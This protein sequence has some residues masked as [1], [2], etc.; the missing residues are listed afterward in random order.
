MIGKLEMMCESSLC[1]TLVDKMN[2]G[3]NRGSSTV[4]EEKRDQVANEDMVVS[5]SS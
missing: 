4:R 1:Q 5:E 3:A 2:P